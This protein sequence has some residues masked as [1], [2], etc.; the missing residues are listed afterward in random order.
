MSKSAKKSGEKRK[1]TLVRLKK[2]RQE[3]GTQK[4][5]TR[6]DGGKQTRKSIKDA[7]TKKKKKVERQEEEGHTNRRCRAWPTEGGESPR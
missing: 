6:V 1:C 3:E 2:T 7:S 4:E 5:K